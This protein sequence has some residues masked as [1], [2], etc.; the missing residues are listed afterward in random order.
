MRC[1]FFYLV[2]MLLDGFRW[3]SHLEKQFVHVAWFDV[4]VWFY[5]LLFVFLLL[6]DSGGCCRSGQLSFQEL[7]IAKL[8]GFREWISIHPLTA[9]SDGVANLDSDSSSHKMLIFA[10]HH[11]VLDGVQVKFLLNCCFPWEW[12]MLVLWLR[13]FLLIV[14][15]DFNVYQHFISIV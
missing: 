5:V 12:F 9:E 13:V 1:I 8:A 14:Y 3:R 11:K 7:G 6:S 2:Y 15:Y 10:H 4:P